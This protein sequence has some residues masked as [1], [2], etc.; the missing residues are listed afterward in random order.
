MAAP[1]HVDALHTCSCRLGYAMHKAR[2]ALS[3][4]EWI[5]LVSQIAHVLDDL[6]LANTYIIELARPAVQQDMSFLA[7][8]AGR[9]NC[10]HY[11]IV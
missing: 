6:R 10:E 8:L 2:S 1:D 4:S 7:A 5:R 3:A 9:N 11:C